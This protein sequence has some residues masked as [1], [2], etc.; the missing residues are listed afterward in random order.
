MFGQP[1]QPFVMEDHG[2]AVAA[3]LYVQLD[4]VPGLD[5]GLEGGAA[6]FDAPLAVQPAM[7]ERS[8]NESPKL[9]LP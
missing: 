7:R 8:R 6:I 1:L 4:A 9:S 3:R 5:R 2:L